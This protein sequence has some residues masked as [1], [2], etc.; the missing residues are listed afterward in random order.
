MRRSKPRRSAARHIAPGYRVDSQSIFS[1]FLR[2]LFT[3]SNSVDVIPFGTGSRLRPPASLSDAERR[4]F[5]DVIVATPPDQFRPS[6]LPLLT[7][8]CELVALADRAA[9]ELRDGYPVTTD[10]K[11]NPWFSI[12][13]QATKA[14]SGLCLRL[15]LSPQS[16]MRRASK[17]KP[18][19]PVL[20]L[21]RPPLMA[22]P[23]H[24]RA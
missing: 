5:V 6:D 1:Q 23:S 9:A 15:R 24:R 19:G 3:A 7:R 18:S 22:G 12:H 8:Y 2:S 21:V 11:I 20:A 16:R 14:I 13:Q 10:G 4:A 17:K